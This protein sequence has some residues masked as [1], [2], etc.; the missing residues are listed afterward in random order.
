M[1]GDMF[2]TMSNENTENVKYMR[3]NILDDLPKCSFNGDCKWRY[4][5]TDQETLCNMCKHKIYYDI[6]SL[7]NDEISNKE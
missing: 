1:S 7:L 2:S 3:V 6:P 4:S 5:L